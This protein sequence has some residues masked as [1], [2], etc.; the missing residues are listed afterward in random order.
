MLGKLYPFNFSHGNEYFTCFSDLYKEVAAICRP[1]LQLLPSEQANVKKA[2]T[3][4]YI[5]SVY[6][7]NVCFG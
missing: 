6:K 2:P 4:A 3:T 5:I 1:P 7:V